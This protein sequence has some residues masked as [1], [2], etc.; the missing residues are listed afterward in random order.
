MQNI[1]KFPEGFVFGTATASYQI[2]GGWQEDGKGEGIWDRFSHIPGKIKNGDT[3][4]IA[5]DSYHRPEE[6][7][8]FSGQLGAGGYRFSISWPRVI[9]EGHGEV[10]EKGLQY[11]DRLVDSLLERGVEPYV[12]LYH[13]D[14]PQALQD[15]GGWAN[16]KT[17]YDFREYARVI[18]EH[19]RGRVRHWITLNEP[20]VS[21][22]V[23][24]YEGKFA[25]GLT[26]FSTALAVAHHQ[27]LG[28]GLAVQLFRE[29]KMDGDIGVV[30]NLCPRKPHTDTQEDRDAARRCDGYANRWFLD[31][32]FR[33]RYPE[34]MTELYRTN[35][36]V[37]P[38]VEDGDMALIS[39]PLDFL[40]INYYCTEFVADDPAQWPV[41]LQIG[42]SNGNPMSD[43]GQPVTP[44]AIREILVRVDREYHPKAIYI[45]ENGASYKDIPDRNDEVHDPM[46]IDYL[47][48]HLSS[49]L[50][51]IEEGVP[52]RGY[53]CWSLFDNFEWASGYSIQFGLIYY[54]H[55]T[56][57]RIPKDS[58][59]WYRDVIRNNG[60]AE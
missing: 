45:T 52:L 6:D 29:M 55:A 38:A 49:C 14:L 22:F 2:E 21:S 43:Y 56:G 19:F 8:D 59:Y 48:R 28:H 51:A 7:A 39:Q 37:L 5:V 47:Y 30:L 20:W 58:F 1:R 18:F 4:D 60:L 9:P 54:D 27:L 17:A 41:F 46:R 35:G 33:G 12:T 34:D 25:P 31:A 53:F 3:A 40:G 26:D 23:G 44:D 10:N 13:W 16:R 11:Y 50:K 15:E 42:Y 24:N 32:V 57:K 36:V